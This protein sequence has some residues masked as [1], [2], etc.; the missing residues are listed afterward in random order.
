M[1]ISDEMLDELIGEAKTQGDL[2]GS[3][4]GISKLECPKITQPILHKFVPTIKYEVLLAKNSGRKIGFT[5]ISARK[6]HKS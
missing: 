4:L 2:F 3:S 5:L 1:K 6:K